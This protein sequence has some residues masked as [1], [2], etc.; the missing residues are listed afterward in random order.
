MKIHC[1]KKLME[2]LPKNLNAAASNIVSLYT[3][4][5]WHANIV[6]I[7][8]KKSIIFVHD[9]TRYCVFLPNMKK[10]DLLQLPYYFEDVFINSL[11]K[12]RLNLEL[13]EAATK[14]V[15]GGA[16]LVHRGGDNVLL[17]AA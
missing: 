2:K 17:R 10:A 8:R 11:I 14:Y 12:S 1:T 9:L 15:N 5:D 7:N 13:I 6:T 16:I 3:I 4:G